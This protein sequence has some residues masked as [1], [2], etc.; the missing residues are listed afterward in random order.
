M[1]KLESIAKEMIGMSGE[2]SDLKNDIICLFDHTEKTVIV[3]SLN[4][5]N[6]RDGKHVAYIEDEDEQIVF[7]IED[8]KIIEAWVRE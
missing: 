3:S 6:E 4:A 7:T 5:F 2:Y 1:T 8:D